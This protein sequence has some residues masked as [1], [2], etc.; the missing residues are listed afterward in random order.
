[1]AQLGMSPEEYDYM[2]SCYSEACKLVGQDAKL[3]PVDS[4]VKDIYLDPTVTYK[5]VR[6]VG[7][8]FENNPKPILKKL[9]WLTEDEELPFV[10]YV[11]AKD[12]SLK[13][14]EVTEN[15]V[16]VVPSVYGLVTER[17]FV[18]SHVR[19][20]SIDPLAWICKLV[21]YRTKLDLDTST[22]EIDSTLAGKN[23]VNYGYL[24]R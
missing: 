12:R 1:M 15:M 4:E 7:V 6:D 21:P 16:L 5:D 24:K 18:V 9:N 23:D 8:L 19:G 13:S 22:E 17:K 2:V 20:T 3:F 11:V 14:F 10:C